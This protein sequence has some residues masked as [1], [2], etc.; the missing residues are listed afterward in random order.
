MDVPNVQ[1]VQI[2]VVLALSG[3]LLTQAVF[4][5]R[6]SVIRLTPTR[7]SCRGQQLARQVTDED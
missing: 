7:R 1:L 6:H 4:E 2:A 5:A 3:A